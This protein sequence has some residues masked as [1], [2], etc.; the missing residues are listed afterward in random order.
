MKASLGMMEN[1][2]SRARYL[3]QHLLHPTLWIL[4]AA[5]PA[6]PRGSPGALGFV[7]AARGPP[8]KHSAGELP[9]VQRRGFYYY[10]VY[11]FLDSVSRCQG[12]RGQS[13]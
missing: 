4:G 5:E 8:S 1:A 13:C 12:R 11:S 3:Q 2:G 7:E 9:R 6:V 10:D